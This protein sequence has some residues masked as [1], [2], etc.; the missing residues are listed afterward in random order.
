MSTVDNKAKKFARKYGKKYQGR[1]CVESCNFG[2]DL[3]KHE[4]LKDV[5]VPEQIVTLNGY[6]QHSPAM[7]EKTGK[8]GHVIRTGYVVGL[9][10]HNGELF[11]VTSDSVYMLYGPWMAEIIKK[12]PF[13]N[14]LWEDVKKGVLAEALNK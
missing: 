2:E 11:A 7:Q 12:Q 14:S 3:V 10:I 4:K 6:M 1:L 9:A 13:L 8:P 5:S